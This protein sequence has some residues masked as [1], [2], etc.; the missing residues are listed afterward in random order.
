MN[1][2]LG[3][4]EF[5]KLNAVIHGISLAVLI[6][7]FAFAVRLGA[8]FDFI[9]SGTL[10]ADLAINSIVAFTWFGKA[11]RT[12]LES[13]VKLWTAKRM[14]PLLF[15][16][17]ACALVGIFTMTIYP[18]TNIA[19]SMMVILTGFLGIDLGHLAKI[20]VRYKRNEKA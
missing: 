11:E 7:L 17:I 4:Y 12:L 14:A 19:L 13:D 2:S 6:I 1:I 9:L 10:L 15:I 18:K 8:L 16:S 3:I 5:Y 20:N